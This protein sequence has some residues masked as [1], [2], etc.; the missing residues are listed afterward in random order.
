MSFAVPDVARLELPR[1]VLGGHYRSRTGMGMG[2]VGAKRLMDELT[3]STAPGLGTAITA[4]KF[5]R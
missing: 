1:A 5:L 2:L 4:R 3:V